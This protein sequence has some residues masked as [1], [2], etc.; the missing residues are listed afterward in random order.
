MVL[1]TFPMWTSHLRIWTMLFV[2]YVLSFLRWNDLQFS[3]RTSLS[4]VT[5]SL[6]GAYYRLNA[7]SFRFPVILSVILDI[8]TP[9]PGGGGGVVGVLELIFAGYVPLASQI[10]YPIIVYFVAN[11]R[12]HL[13]HFW[14][15]TKFSRSQLSI[16]EITLY[17]MKNT[18]LFTYSTNIL[19][20]LLTVN[21]KNCLAPKIR[22][23]ATPF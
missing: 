13:S 4:S 21:M 16:Y 2:R 10:P 20:R 14:A 8:N 6:T 18:L 11:Y 19:A 15:N 17:W 12:P 5:C 9:P 22:K 23:C 7:F 3:N 1:F